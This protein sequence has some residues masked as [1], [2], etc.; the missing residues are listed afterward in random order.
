VTQQST[1]APVIPAPNK[2]TQAFWD[3]AREHKLCIQR[4]NH[5]GK[6]QHWP[7]PVCHHC[8]SFDLGYAETSGR[9]TVY[10]YEIATQ[11][12]HPYFEDKLPFVIAIVELDD[13]PNLKMI[14]N[15]VDFPDGAITVGAP[16]EVTFR[17]LDDQFTLPVFRPA[18]A[19]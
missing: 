4:C 2:L 19:G 12:F 15:L 5:C 10:S 1:V 9:G 17:E 18:D 11:A 13:Q 14:T 7:E 8:L 6:F 3:G 16:V